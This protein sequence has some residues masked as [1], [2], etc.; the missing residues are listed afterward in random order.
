MDAPIRAVAGRFRAM[1]LKDEPISVNFPA[2][3]DDI[4]DMVENIRFIEPNITAE[5]LSSA[6]FN[7]APALQKFVE[8]HCHSSQ[9]AFQIKKCLDPS[10][11]YCVEHAVVMDREEFSGISFLPLPLLDSTKAHF[12][13][14]SEMYGKPLSD[15][16]RPSRG[17]FSNPE[18]KKLI[19]RTKLFLTAA[20]LGMLLIV[21]SAGSHGV[22][23]Q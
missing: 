4:T 22:C 6:V 7:N 13:P 5:D 1:K 17:L 9:Y 3:N 20:R 15:K 23:M 14:F 8:S 10:C 21:R 18:L 11:Y 19:I 2:T 12:S 16:D